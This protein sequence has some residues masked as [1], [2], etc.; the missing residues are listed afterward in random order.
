MKHE[1]NKKQILVVDDEYVNIQLAKGLLEPEGYI[2]LE[3]LDGKAGLELA[4][5]KSPDLILLDIL[6]PKLNGYEV[7][8]QLKSCAETQ[9]IPIIMVT[10]L[11]DKEDRIKGIDVDVDDFLTKP[12]DRAEIIARVKSLLRIKSLHDELQANYKKLQELEHLKDSLTHMIV[13]D[14]NNLLLVISGNLQ[15]LNMHYADLL[16][17]KDKEG[18]SAALTASDDLGQMV[19]NLLD[20]NKMEQGVIKLNYEYFDLKNIAEEVIKQMEF[21]SS[22]KNINVSLVVGHDIPAISA[23]K[24]LV[25]RIIANLIRNALKFSSDNSKVEVK[26]FFKHDTYEFCIQIK[27]SGP[28]IAEEYLDKVF[29]K[30]FQ[31]NVKDAKKGYGLGLAFCKLAVEAHN[32]NIW[33]TSEK[34]KGCVFTVTLPV[35]I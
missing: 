3:A 23:D 7:C 6:M 29:E 22:S 30:F 14:M 12:I 9:F 24:G 8:K 25:K 4:K 2:I 11:K 31:I 1:K 19:S 26:I 32:G 33:V 13:H 10:A 27:D 5:E 21:Y 34:G 28:G 15:L 20:V 18:L 35:G 17:G 16:P